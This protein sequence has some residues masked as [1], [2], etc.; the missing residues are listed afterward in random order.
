M[1][2]GGICAAAEAKVRVPQELSVIG[3]DDI[4]LASYSTPR[5][6]TMAQPKYAMG[7]MITHLA[8]RAHRGGH[9]PLRRELLKTTLIERQSTAP[10]PP[11]QPPAKPRLTATAAAHCCIGDKATRCIPNYRLTR[12]ALGVYSRNR[13]RN[14]LRDDKA[15]C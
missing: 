1:A 4:A 14:R 15:V 13:L 2:I 9:L 11:G 6:T 5:L 10:W 7:E 12:N 8:A 3:Y